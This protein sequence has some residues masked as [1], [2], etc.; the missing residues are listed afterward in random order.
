ML[1]A[2]YRGAQA[3]AYMVH[4]LRKVPIPRT[5]IAAFVQVVDIGQQFRPRLEV[6]PAS[7]SN[8]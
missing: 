7:F 1:V 8:R 6:E 3:L 4:D 5:L 2:V